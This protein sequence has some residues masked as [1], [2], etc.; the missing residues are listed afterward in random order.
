M[1]GYN[2]V[3]VTQDTYLAA[4]DSNPTDLTGYYTNMTQLMYDNYSEVWL[5][6]PTSFAVYASDLHGYVQNPM[7]SAEPFAIGFNTQWLS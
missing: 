6:V 4:S 7:A 2:N 1:A 5:V 3:T